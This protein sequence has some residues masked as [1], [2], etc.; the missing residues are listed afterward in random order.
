[1]LQITT[2]YCS[3]HEEWQF[4]G[5]HIPKV[6]HTGMYSRI[7][8]KFNLSKIYVSSSGLLVTMI[9]V[10]LLFVFFTFFFF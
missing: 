2:S 10:L 5:H 3:L 6:M 8:L 9:F 7:Y 1:M 4:H